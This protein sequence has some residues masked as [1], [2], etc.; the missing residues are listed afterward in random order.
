[1]SRRA[2]PTLI[3]A[4]VVG[5]IALAVAGALVL[6]G[7]Q[8]FARP[9][10]YVV[11]FDGSVAGLSVGSPVQYRGVPVGSVTDIRAVSGATEIAVFIALDISRQ[12]FLAAGTGVLSSPDVPTAVR[13]A[14]ARGLRAQLQNQSLV[15]GQLYV[16]LDYFPNTPVR[17]TGLDPFVPEI[18]AVPTTVEQASEQL[19]RLVARV[20]GLP[21]EQL[22]KSAVGAVDA[23]RTLVESAE[24]RQTL[25]GIDTALRDTRTLV[26]TLERQV[27]PVAA[28]AQQA[29]DAARLAVGDLRGAI[30]DTVRK[31]DQQLDPLVASTGQTLDATRAMMLDAQRLVRETTDLVGPL[32]ASATT[33]ADAARVTLERAQTTLGNADGLLTE[34]SPLGYQLGQTLQE[35]ADAARA[36]RGLADGLERQPSSL[37]FGKRPAASR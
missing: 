20:E 17:L 7:R 36:L 28:S 8:W 6:G 35:L 18:P 9:E 10:T 11:F 27:G 32:A 23:L 15:T 25:T 3:G 2:N 16:G 4:F 34:E 21:V 1:M 24:V 14:V 33:T 29:L 26:V 22:F 31:L 12:K 37:L 30:G 13:N 5:A 19:K